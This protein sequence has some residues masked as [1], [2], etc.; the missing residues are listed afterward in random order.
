M[1]TARTLLRR[2]ARLVVIL[3][4]AALL[5]VPSPALA[6]PFILGSAENFA[7]L[8]GSAV[9]NT[10]PTTLNGDL[11]VSPGSSITGFGSITL[12]GASQNRGNGAVSQQAQ[13]DETNAYNI[14]K[15]QP[16]TMDLTGHDLGT[17]GIS[18]LGTLTPGTYRF[19]S[20]AQLNGPLTLD[21]QGN[22]NAQFIFQIG[23]ALTTASASSVDVI[24]GGSNAG[25][26]WLLGV[27]G[28]AGTGSATLGTTTSFEGNILALDSIT[29]NTGA[30][31]LCGRALA[32]VGAV[33]MDTNTISNN[34]STF[35]N[36]T[37]TSDFGSRGFGGPG[38]STSPVPEP[39]SV[40]LLI[41]GLISVAALRR[42]RA[43]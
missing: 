24:N 40:L 16:F 33:T 4:F 39:A 19:S 5:C 2:S 13:A 10:G 11:G 7:V 28:G 32:Q 3:P 17:T 22:P 31:I 1:K 26:F 36:G 9:T 35:N 23:T 27:T 37:G 15:V 20:T 34:C 8:G 12:E 38:S 30:T 43:H 14:L 18:P 41:T 6:L 29:L 42:A 21:A 25:V